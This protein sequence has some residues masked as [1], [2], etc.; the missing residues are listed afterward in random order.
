MPKCR[1]RS[2]FERCATDT[3]VEIIQ[4]GRAQKTSEPFERIIVVYPARRTGRHCRSCHLA[5]EPQAD[6]AELEEDKKTPILIFVT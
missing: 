1:A 3:S 4:T 6:F 2:L 5:L